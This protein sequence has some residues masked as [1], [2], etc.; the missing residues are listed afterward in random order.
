MD[1]SRL[2]EL[3]YVLYGLLIASLLAVMALGSVAR[4]SRRAID[5]PF[6]SFQASE[7]VKVLLIVVARRLRGRPH[8]ARRRQTGAR[9]RASCCWG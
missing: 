6:F 2:R 9:P 1:Y 7:I 8:A 5:L 3:K 4:G